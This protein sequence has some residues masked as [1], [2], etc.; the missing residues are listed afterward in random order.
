[1]LSAV[2]ISQA[3]KLVIIRN[4]VES[5]NVRDRWSLIVIKVIKERRVHVM[6]RSSGS[7]TWEFYYLFQVWTLT[8]DS[9]S[10]IQL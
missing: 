7:Y 4:E 5:S 8:T 3:L 6:V 1:M 2:V 9:L 10:C